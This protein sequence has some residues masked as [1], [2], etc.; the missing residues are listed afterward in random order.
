LLYKSGVA[1]YHKLTGYLFGWS[2]S[3][4]LSAM[5]FTQYGYDGTDPSAYCALPIAR[6]K[7]NVAQSMIWPWNFQSLHS[8]GWVP[9]K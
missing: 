4:V 2:T 5:A 7:S 8:D 6:D 3:H 9:E 1:V